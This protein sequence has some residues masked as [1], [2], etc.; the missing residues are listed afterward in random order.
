MSERRKVQ[1]W[2]QFEKFF[3]KFWI[4]LLKRIVCAHTK[5]YFWRFFR[6]KRVHNSNFNLDSRS[7]YFTINKKKHKADK[8]SDVLPS[9]VGDQSFEIRIRL[10]R[11]EKKNIRRQIQLVEKACVAS[12]SQQISMI[13]L[14]FFSEKICLTFF[15]SIAPI[16]RLRFW[17]YSKRIFASIRFVF[18]KQ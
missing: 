6:I 10:F 12:H 13:I 8:N 11:S 17:D 14:V 2:D 18:E 5:F 16:Q 4:G 3:P 7:I 1:F 15:E 9:I